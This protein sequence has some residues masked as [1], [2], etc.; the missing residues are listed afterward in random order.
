MK[1]IR[2]KCKY[3]I[4]GYHKD[5]SFVVVGLDAEKNKIILERLPNKTVGFP[6]A[7]LPNI[8]IEV[9]TFKELFTH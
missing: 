1:E 3:P 5:D 2:Y 4:I 8:E 6:Q 9:I 7:V